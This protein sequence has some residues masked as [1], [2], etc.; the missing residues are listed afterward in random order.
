MSRAIEANGLGPQLCQHCRQTRDD[1][2]AFVVSWP[3]LQGRTW[4][5]DCFRALQVRVALVSD[6]V[7]AIVCREV[8]PEL[9][10]VCEKH[11]ESVG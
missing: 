6:C 11:A 9:W 2:D 3:G 4:C 8:D 7:G 10:L 5:R 1:C